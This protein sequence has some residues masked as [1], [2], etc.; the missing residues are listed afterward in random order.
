MHATANAIKI[1]I[2]ALLTSPG[3]VNANGV[4]GP[5]R[6]GG[7]LSGSVVRLLWRHPTTI[8]ATDSGVN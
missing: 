3:S 4:V 5:R 8:V 1:A 7:A 2:F 6:G